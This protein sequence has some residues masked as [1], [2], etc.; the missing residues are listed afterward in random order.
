VAAV[1]HWLGLL[2]LLGPSCRSGGL[3][4]VLIISRAARPPSKLSTAPSWSE[5]TLGVDLRVVGTSTDEIYA[6]MD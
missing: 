3:A 2:A 4:L 6:A 5:T 1:A